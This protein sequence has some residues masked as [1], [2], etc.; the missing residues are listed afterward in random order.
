MLHCV[1]CCVCRK[2][3]F[4]GQGLISLE[5][6]EG[7]CEAHVCV[8]LVDEKGRKPSGGKVEVV[9]RLREPLTG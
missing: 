3:L 5:K 6:L 1:P 8:D 9:A 2:D 4:I 7:K